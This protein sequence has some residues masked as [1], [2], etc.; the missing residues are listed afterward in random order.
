MSVPCSAQ[1]AFRAERR[2]SIA[3]Q[4]TF[5]SSIRVSGLASHNF[6]ASSR[7]FAITV[8]GT[9]TA[10]VTLQRSIGAPGSWTDVESYTV[11][12]S[13]V[14]DDGLDNQIIYYRLG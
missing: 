3:A 7:S 14:Y 10:T 13:K 1:H 12:T 9:F 5:T 11:P 2:A 8:D 6:S 4:N